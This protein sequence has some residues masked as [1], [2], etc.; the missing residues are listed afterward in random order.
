MLKRVGLHSRNI[1]W[2]WVTQ[3]KIIQSVD[4]D[5]RTFIIIIIIIIIIINESV[6]FNTLRRQ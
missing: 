6:L 1:T 3:G 4:G 2:C 5:G